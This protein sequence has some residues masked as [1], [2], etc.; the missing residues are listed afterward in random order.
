MHKSR[1]QQSC[2]MRIS[3]DPGNAQR[4]QPTLLCISW[5]PTK[6]HM[7]VLCISWIIGNVQKQGPTK[8]HN[9]HFLWSRKC[10]KAGTNLIVHFL[11][12]RKCTKALWGQPSY[13]L[14]IFWIIGNAQKQGPTKLHNAHFLWSRKCTEGGPNLAC[15]TFPMLKEMDKIIGPQVL[16]IV[17]FR[18]ISF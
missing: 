14:C 16:L 1:G 3:Y 13:I 9:V 12:H 18:Q 7:Y 5:T 6:L 11:D 4:Q 15:C 10:A 17:Y 8:L 2:I